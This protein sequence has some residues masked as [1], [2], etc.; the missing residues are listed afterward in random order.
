MS[1][2]SRLIRKI[3]KYMSD[4]I[5]YSREMGVNIGNDCKLNGVPNWGS[6]P[7]LISLGNHTEV[8]F[9]VTFITHDGATWC[10]RN[11]EKYRRVIK[12]GRITIGN[13]CF[14][15]A[16]SII[17][18]GVHVGDNSIIAAGAVVT[19]DIPE[20]QVWGGNPARFIT[21]TQEYAEKCLLLTPE[22]DVN[23]LLNHKKNE[24]LRI[25]N[26]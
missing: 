10:F 7:Y 1:I 4:P 24:V 25:T 5:S 14:V 13:N 21:T 8:S 3:K 12:F 23:E 16:R 6:E 15:G 26:N 19:K 17:L 18:P 11:Q 22:Y 20:G 2:F 9:E